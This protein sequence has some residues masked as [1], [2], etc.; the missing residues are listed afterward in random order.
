M[1][2]LNNDMDHLLRQAAD[3]FEVPPNGAD[4]QK[5]AAALDNNAEVVN[6]SKIW[7]HSLR[8]GLLLIF[9]LASLVCNKYLYLPFNRPGIVSQNGKSVTDKIENIKNNPVNQTATDWEPKQINE[10]VSTQVSG[11][12]KT[13]NQNILKPDSRTNIKNETRVES[14][15]TKDKVAPYYTIHN[16]RF[17]AFEKVINIQQPHIETFK[18][19]EIPFV[20]AAPF[21]EDEAIPKENGKYLKRKK[22]RL[23]VGVVAGPDISTVKFEESSEPGYTAG[24]VAGYQYN[25]RWAV[26]TGLLWNKKNYYT[27]GK[28]FN[29]SKLKLPSHTNIIYAE[30]Y[31]NM[32]EIPLNVRYAF[33]HNKKH[34]WFAAAGASSYLMQKEDYHYLYERYN[35]TYYSSKSYKAA[36]TNWFSVANISVGYV[37]EKSN[38]MNIRIEP[39]LKVPI[40]GMGIG[41]LPITSTGI[42]VGITYPVQ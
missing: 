41:K 29:T 4:W 14:N 39:Y 34:H 31:C 40:S 24:L 42:Q 5:V 7:M 35:V 6:E 8:Y 28:H 19:S 25:K 22:G 17:S 36:S 21:I 2:P 38:G 11:A 37:Y 10:Y 9:L 33:A 18:T 13:Y 32:F 16:S 26:E 3:V 30:G 1:Q 15:Q 12:L 23:Y 27:Q 20:N